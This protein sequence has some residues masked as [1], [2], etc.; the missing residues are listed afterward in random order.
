MSRFGRDE[1]K[2]EDAKPDEPAAKVAKPAAVVDPL[3]GKDP[4][5]IKANEAILAQPVR[6]APKGG[7]GSNPAPAAAKFPELEPPPPPEEY[8]VAPVT[9]EDIVREKF[10]ERPNVEALRKAVHVR[11]RTLDPLS[12]GVY[13]ANEFIDR[14]GRVIPISQVTLRGEAHLAALATDPRIEVELVD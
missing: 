12:A 4:E 3:A 5:F 9:P 1:T 2:P 10:G 11:A 6:A 13:V 8:R 14:L 7:E